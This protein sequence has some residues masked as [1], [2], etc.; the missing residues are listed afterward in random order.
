M[1]LTIL[2]ITQQQALDLLA[3]MEVMEELLMTAICEKSE[4][5]IPLDSNQRDTLATTA[6][7]VSSQAAYMAKN[8]R[9]LT[10]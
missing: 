6:N 9:N 8:L 5:P 2:G 1:I 7:Q 3:H 10:R 4:E